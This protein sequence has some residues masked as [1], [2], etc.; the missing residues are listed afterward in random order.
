MSEAGE[1]LKSG[2]LDKGADLVHKLAGPVFEE[3]GAMLAD[4]VRVWRVKNLISTVK[5]TERLL[6]DAGPPPNAVPPRLL[7]PILENSSLEDNETLQEMWAGLLAS[8][9]QERDSVS[10]SFVETLKQLT[11]EE[12]RQLEYV[13]AE[14]AADVKT[15]VLLPGATVPDSLWRG[16]ADEKTDISFDTFERLGLI[17]RDWST[18]LENARHLQFDREERRNFNAESINEGLITEYTLLFTDYGARFLKA[19]HGPSPTISE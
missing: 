6:L 16:S 10:P 8:A 5:R 11:P 2:F 17:R 12:A 7:L 18:Y 14:T 3:F 9:S 4:K 13:A 1:I 19:C 15:N